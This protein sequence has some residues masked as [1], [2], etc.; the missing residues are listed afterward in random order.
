M[1]EIVAEVDT[2][3]EAVETESAAIANASSTTKITTQSIDVDHDG[4]GNLNGSNATSTDTTTRQ[5]VTSNIGMM[6]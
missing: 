3:I 1:P 5:H 2:Y 6:S 4:L